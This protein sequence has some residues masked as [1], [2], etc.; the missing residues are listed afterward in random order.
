MSENDRRTLPLV[1][2]C[3]PNY[4][5]GH[6]LEHCLDSIYNQTYP[7][8][9]VLFRDNHSSDG[10]YD[11]A[12][13]WRHKFLQKG[14]YFNVAENKKNLGSSRNSSILAGS[15]EGEFIYTLASDDAIH[16]TFIERCMDVFV[17]NPNVSTVITHREEIDES[18]RIYQTPSFYNVDCIIDKESQAAV[19]MMAGIA[20][21][22]QRMFRLSTF[23][24]LRMYGKVLQVAGDWYD[25]YLYCMGGDVA[26]I[27]EPLCQYRIHTGNETTESELSLIG[28]VEHFLLLDEFCKLADAFGLSKPQKR[29]G[30]AVKKLAQMCLR[31]AMKMY[32]NKR[33][34]VAGRYLTLALVYAGEIEE[35][36]A[37]QML[38]SMVDLT[39]EKLE[40]EIKRFEGKY[41][42]E[43]RASYDPPAGYQKINK[44]GQI[45]D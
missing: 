19:Y 23:R 34:D 41:P 14:I 24:Q 33:N 8:L 44:S 26:Y 31:Y 4:N 42:Q 37:Y 3:I 10:S 15:A 22:V 32:K 9:E 43:R 29:Y 1:S 20:V 16:P 12:L 27:A 38:K 7:N 39:G 28:S 21:P 13:E 36:P 40:A 18:G 5:Y 25:N 35:E 6:Y 45:I 11:I 17:N 30:E 2:I